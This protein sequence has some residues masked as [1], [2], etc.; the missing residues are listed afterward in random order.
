MESKSKKE[1]QVER[2][3]IKME[4]NLI[5]KPGVFQGGTT[6]INKWGN[7]N[8]VR[9]PKAL[10]DMLGLSD[11]DA[12]RLYVDRADQSIILKKDRQKLRLEERL[13]KFYGMP[14]DQIPPVN[15]EEVD[16]GSPVGK[17]EW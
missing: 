7:S 9:L 16:W 11:G 14:I 10:L 8:G 17:E 5:R 13:E 1:N 12:M 6:V 15:A 2:P 4:K 3:K